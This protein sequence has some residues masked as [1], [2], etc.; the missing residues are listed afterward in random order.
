LKKLLL[1][2]KN[3]EKHEKK[4]FK[5]FENLKIPILML[6]VLFFSKNKNFHRNLPE[7]GR[8]RE[9]DH[10]QYTSLNGLTNA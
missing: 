7:A 1:A 8:F 9:L 2:S 6:E 10:K 4:Y 5:N 3:S